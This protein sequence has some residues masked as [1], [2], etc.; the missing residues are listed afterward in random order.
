MTYEEGLEYY[1]A[2]MRASEMLVSFPLNCRHNEESRL[3]S[4]QHLQGGKCFLPNVERCPLWSGPESCRCGLCMTPLLTGHSGPN[5]HRRVDWLS[6]LQ[7]ILC[8]PPN[9]SPKLEPLRRVPLVSS[10]GSPSQIR[11]HFL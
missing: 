10:W 2:Q 11:G 6:L 4:S 7:S 5:S 8:L 9:L 1:L 3:R